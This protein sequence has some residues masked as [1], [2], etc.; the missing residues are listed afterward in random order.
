MKIFEITGK[1]T[2]EWNAEAEAI[3]DTWKSYSVTLEEFEEAILKGID[4]AVAHGGVAWVADS[5]KAEG[6]FSK[7]IQN[8]I[9]SDIL[10]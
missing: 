7:E 1:L 6:Q 5:R 9:V 4:Y 3:V 10:P 2:V 8:F